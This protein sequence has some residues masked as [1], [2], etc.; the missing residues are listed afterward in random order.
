MYF[1]VSQNGDP[2]QPVGLRESLD[3]TNAWQQVVLPFRATK[4]LKGKARWIF[5]LG[6]DDGDVYLAL[7]RLQKGGEVVPLLAHAGG[8]PGD[9]LGPRGLLPLLLEEMS[10]SRE[11]GAARP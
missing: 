3:T 4:S 7:P 8:T 6:N 11:R 5:K 9:V 10:L 2:W 1:D